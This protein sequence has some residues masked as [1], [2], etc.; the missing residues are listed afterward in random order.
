MQPSSLI[1]PYSILAAESE[2][3][4]QGQIAGPIVAEGHVF[5]MKLEEKQDAG[6]EPF[7]TV[8]DQVR[9]YIIRKRG[10]KA[11]EPLSARVRRQAKLGRTNEFIEFCLEKIYRMSRPQ[12]RLPN[13][14]S[15][16]RDIEE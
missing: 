7:E 1:A 6:Y 5:I 10:I 15:E 16:G 8:Q 2:K 3:M 13:Q 14:D 4:Q 11:R 9:E 12:E